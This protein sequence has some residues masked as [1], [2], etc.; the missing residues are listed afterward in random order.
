[1][2]TTFEERKADGIKLQRAMLGMVKEFEEKHGVLVLSISLCHRFEM[3]S[4]MKKTI[5]LKFE[6]QL[7]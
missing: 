7:P 4:M 2:A 5:D 6:V 1:M 3:S